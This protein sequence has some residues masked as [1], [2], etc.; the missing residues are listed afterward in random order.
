MK[1]HQAPPLNNPSKP[2]LKCASIDGDADRLVY[3]YV[4]ENNE[5]NLLDG[6]KIAILIVSYLKE[7]IEAS[8]LSI[9]LGLVQT[10]Y[11]NGA[12]TNYVTETLVLNIYYW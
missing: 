11:A 3:Y 8:G 5:F 7:L 9:K 12:S 6:D 10:A 4:D 2:Y 1:I